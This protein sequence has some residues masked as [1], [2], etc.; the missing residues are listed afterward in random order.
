MASIGRSSYEEFGPRERKSRTCARTP[1]TCS[2]SPI[3]S[4]AAGICEIEQIL[5]TVVSPETTTDPSG[6]RSDARR[7]A[8]SDGG[9]PAL[10]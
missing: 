5:L 8:R 10:L 2:K 4:A 6:C 7:L 3:T 9:R 1:M